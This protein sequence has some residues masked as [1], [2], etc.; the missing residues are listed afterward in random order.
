MSY[1]IKFGTD[2]WRGEIAENYT[3]RQRAPVHPGICF[4]HE[5]PGKQGGSIV[6]GYDKRFQSEKFALAVS[7]VLAANG[8]QSAANQWPDPTPVIAYAVVQQ[9]RLERSTSPP[10]TT[11]RR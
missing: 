7:E 6:V 2:G 4:L 11:R 9:R 10:R 1:K 5:Q 8:F 3:F